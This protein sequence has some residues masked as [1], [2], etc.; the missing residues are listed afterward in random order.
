MRIR[1]L[2]LA[3]ALSA[4][5]L[6]LHLW[7]TAEFLYWKFVWFDS[8]MH[9]LG[10]ITLGVFVATLLKAPQPVKFYGLILVLIVG[11]ELFEFLLG[12]PRKDNYAFDT[13]LDLCLGVL[14]ASLAYYSARRS[15]WRSA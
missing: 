8:P 9:L 5:L 12:S 6:S 15:L 4:L 14:G 3:L 1:W 11:W 7:G 2:L 10:G 13:V